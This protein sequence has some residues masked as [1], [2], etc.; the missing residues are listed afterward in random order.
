[1]SR[2]IGLNR[3]EA[4]TRDDEWVRRWYEANQFEMAD[5]Y[6]HVYMDGKEELKEA[7]KSDVPKL[8]PVQ[9]FAHYVGEDRELMKRKFK[10][11]HECVCYEKYLSK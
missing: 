7:L 8:Y 5:S 4:W 11:V 2:K 1:M 9:G 3:L 10:R 6:L